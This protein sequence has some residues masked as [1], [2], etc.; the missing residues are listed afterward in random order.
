MNSLKSKILI[1]GWATIL[2]FPV[3]AYVVLHFFEQISFVEFIEVEKINVL[4]I[5]LGMQFG[6]VFAIF[7]LLLLQSPFFKSIP[8]NIESLVK[9]MNLSIFDAVFLSICAGIGEELLFRI[10]IQYYLHWAITSVLFVALHGYL[11]PWN[12][13]FSMYGIALLPFVLV[14]SLAYYTFGIWFCIAAHFMYDF[15]VFYSIVKN[16]RND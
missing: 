5:G 8:N 14:I 10:G 4:S 15:V 11:N 16:N 2:L 7:I 12:W 13:R 9:S 3:P 6:F 1:L